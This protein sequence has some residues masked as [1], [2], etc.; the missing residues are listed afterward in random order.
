MND[1]QILKYKNFEG[2]VEVSLE[3]GCL[4]GK[5]LF[6]RDAIMYEGINVSEIQAEFEKAVDQYLEDCTTLNREPNK[7]YSGT[8]NVRTGR[9]RHEALASYANRKNITLNDAVNKGIDLLLVNVH[10]QIQRN[11]YPARSAKI[12]MVA[13]QQW[14]THIRAIN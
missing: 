5:V 8:F 13:G 10:V 6:I 4:Y 12:S 1:K 9:S 3:D 7:P 11:V 14:P 2:S